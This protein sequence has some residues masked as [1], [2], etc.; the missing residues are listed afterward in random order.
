MTQK[1][2]LQKAYDILSCT[3]PDAVE[4]IGD[5]PR[6]D[7]AIITALQRNAAMYGI[8]MAAMASVG[9][10]DLNNVGVDLIPLQTLQVSK[11]QSDN[12]HIY[13]TKPVEL[14]I[15]TE[16]MT[17]EE[18]YPMVD[19][20]TLNNT[21]DV[22][23]QFLGVNN[24]IALAA[25]MEGF[26]GDLHKDPGVGLNIGF[27]YNITKRI[28]ENPEQ[29]LKDLALV[30]LS[31]EI[32]EKLVHLS[33]IPQSQLSRGIREFNRENPFPDNQLITLVQGVSLLSATQ[34]EY[35]EQARQ[36]FIA[37]FDLMGKN[38]QEVLTYAAYKIGQESLSRYR[39]AIMAATTIHTDNRENS[40]GDYKKVAEELKFYYRL[41]GQEWTLDTRASLV[42]HSFVSQDYLALKI[43]A[44]DA[45][46]LSNRE[47]EK[48]KVDFSHLPTTL[49]QDIQ[50]NQSQKIGLNIDKLRQLYDNNTDV[51]NK[52][53]SYGHR[54]A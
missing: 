26:R 42:A 48:Y 37:S 36:A 25:E 34:S 7:R 6:E 16:Y 45:I 8:G 51:A 53:I 5:R 2:L 31:P 22:S 15:Y 39:R 19:F 52:K 3:N 23:R 27:G 29:V 30:G 24:F 44:T 32:I 35:K 11:P 21:R 1:N 40:L 41:D 43:G 14:K 20:S 12:S 28:Q 17:V 38:Q 54:L 46:T 33:Q 50:I 4:I 10:V 9:F 13:N 18:K 49:S 47:L